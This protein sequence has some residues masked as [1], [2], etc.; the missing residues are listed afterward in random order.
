MLSY[1]SLD[2]LKKFNTKRLLAYKRKVNH[3][4][5]LTPEFGFHGDCDCGDCADAS[6]TAAEW[7]L[8]LNNIKAVLKTREH[9]NKE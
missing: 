9:I 3:L 2:S 5:N 6:E 8:V 7:S 4:A 1:L